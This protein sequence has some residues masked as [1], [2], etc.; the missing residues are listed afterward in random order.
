M[1]VVSYG[2]ALL[3][4]WTETLEYGDTFPQLLFTVVLLLVGQHAIADR[5][6]LRLAGLWIALLAFLAFIARLVVLHGVSDPWILTAAAIRG[7]LAAGLITGL[8]WLVLPLL[9]LFYE[10]LIEPVLRRPREW[11]ERVRL[12]REGRQFRHSQ[13]QDQQ[14]WERAAPEREAEATKAAKQQRRQAAEQQQRDETRFRI[15]LLIDQHREQLGDR[16]P[17]A[18]LQRYFVDYLGDGLSSKEVQ[19]RADQLREMVLE[20]VKPLMSPEKS[21]HA[22]EGIDE[23][24]AHFR[25]KKDRILA[26]DYSEPMKDIFLMDVEDAEKKAIQEFLK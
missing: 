13:R 12:W 21:P 22:F 2:L 10:S 5:P 18:W 14:A 15:R 25:E 26:T 24:A 11:F 16:F 20:T 19:R 8:S 1:P 9:A 17:D 3:D 4:E 7:L 6:R 23:I